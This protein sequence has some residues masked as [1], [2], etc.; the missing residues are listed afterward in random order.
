MNGKL[1]TLTLGIALC[2]WALTDEGIEI[3]P[4]RTDA[5]NGLA[6][7]EKVFNIIIK[8][9]AERGKTTV[10]VDCPKDR[11]LTYYPWANN[12]P[13]EVIKKEGNTFGLKPNEPKKTFTLTAQTEIGGKEHKETAEIVVTNAQPSLIVKMEKEDAG[14]AKKNNPT[15]KNYGLSTGFMSG[16]KVPEARWIAHIYYKDIEGGLPQNFPKEIPATI[17][18]VDSKGKA[19]DITYKKPFVFTVEASSMNHNNDREKSF[20]FKVKPFDFD[21]KYHDG[22]YFFKVV[23]SLKDFF[24]VTD[25]IGQKAKIVNEIPK[26][27]T[28]NLLPSKN[29]SKQYEQSKNKKK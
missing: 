20:F 16:S 1:F 14:F 15:E 3:K 24:A 9:T 17:Y 2:G 25:E 28:V 4:H 11:P 27:L 29:W 8:G 23:L 18:V 21:S 26:E 6:R 7:W 12:R 19:E 10:T 13:F 22:E 5:V